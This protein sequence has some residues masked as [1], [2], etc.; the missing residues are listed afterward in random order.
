MLLQ[1]DKAGKPIIPIT[2]MRVPVL[3]HDETGN[4][5]LPKDQTGQKIF[6]RNLTDHSPITLT[7]PLDELDRAIIA[8][9]Q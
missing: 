8:N 4:L 2:S 3:N 6:P 9:N 1:T 5:I 7:N